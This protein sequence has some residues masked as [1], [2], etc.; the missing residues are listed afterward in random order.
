MYR[1]GFLFYQF[2][3]SHWFISASLWN[4]NFFLRENLE[5]FWHFLIHDPTLLFVNFDNVFGRGDVKFEQLWGFGNRENLFNNEFNEGISSLNQ[6]ENVPFRIFL[7]TFS[8]SYS[9]S[10]FYLMMYEILCSEFIRTFNINTLPQED[11]EWYIFEIKAPN[12]CQ[13]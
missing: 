4:K 12:E 11:L 5:C 13:W 3:S 7:R 10:P 1:L 2:L 6:M 8:M 9:L